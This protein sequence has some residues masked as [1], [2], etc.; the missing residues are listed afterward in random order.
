MNQNKD[1]IIHRDRNTLMMLSGSLRVFERTPSCGGESDSA[2]TCADLH[3]I[4]LDRHSITVKWQIWRE[5][6]LPAVATNLKKP[7]CVCQSGS[8]S[9]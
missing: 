5:R 2:R 1:D 3:I 4:V 7:F 8:L 6:Q 9:F